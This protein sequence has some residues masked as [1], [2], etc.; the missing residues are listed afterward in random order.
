MTTG[1]NNS[2]DCMDLTSYYKVRAVN[3]QG[4][5]RTAI[6]YDSRQIDSEYRRLQAILEQSEKF[7]DLE[8]EKFAR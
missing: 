8:V 1:T 7:R 6:I 3:H 2:L 4:L 5:V